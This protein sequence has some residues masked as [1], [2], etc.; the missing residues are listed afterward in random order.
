MLQNI[1]LGD[2][3]KVIA[4]KIGIAI[5]PCLT[6]YTFDCILREYTSMTPGTVADSL[7]G[8]MIPSGS[9]SGTKLQQNSA[10]SL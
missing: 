4:P 1:C 8:N 9:I 10:G 5:S 6:Q 7:E 2:A 3:V